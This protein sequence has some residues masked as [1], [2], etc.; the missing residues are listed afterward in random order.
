MGAQCG[1]DLDQAFVG[2][3]GEHVV[4]FFAGA[5]EDR[6][7]QAGHLAFAGLHAQGT[8][9]GLDDVDGGAEDVCED[10]RIAVLGVHALTEYPHRCQHAP[11]HHRALGVGAGGELA[12]HVP[13]VG[14][15]VL[16]VQP[17]RPD[18]AWLRVRLGVAL[19]QGFGHGRQ[20]AGEG[21]GFACAVVKS[22]Q[23]PQPVLG[24]GLQHGGLQ[25]GQAGAADSIG[26]GVLPDQLSRLKL[27][28]GDVHA[29]NLILRDQAPLDRVRQRQPVH[30]RPEH[31][32]VIHRR[33]QLTR[34]PNP[35]STRGVTGRSGL[36]QPRGR[37]HVQP[38]QGRQP[39]IV[40]DSRPRLAQR[41]RGSVRFVY[42]HQIP[43]PQ[44]RRVC[45]LQDSEPHRCIRGEQ[46]DPPPLPS[47]RTSSP[48]SV[49]HGIPSASPSDSEHAPNNW[50]VRPPSRHTVAI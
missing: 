42:H 7:D 2:A 49:V 34:P 39:L 24:P 17:L 30:H 8:A 25:R 3:G 41:P 26:A 10:D 37:R 50:P 13:S 40:M 4:G 45:T 44:P 6:D 11:L 29:H 48:G 31:S 23:P 47:H 14:G 27:R 35:T 32:L 18:R 33:H 21:L 28:V 19:P 43:R 9:D 1:Q 22:Q 38:A 12:Q 46:R 36:P 15:L 20:A 16:P 5:E